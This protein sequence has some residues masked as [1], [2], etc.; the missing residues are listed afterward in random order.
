MQR[1]CQFEIISVS[2]EENLLPCSTEW[3]KSCF[4]DYAKNYNQ[5]LD[6]IF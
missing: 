3:D 5:N 6:Y 4:I 2:R 1:T